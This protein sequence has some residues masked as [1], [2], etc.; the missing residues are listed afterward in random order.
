MMGISRGIS[1][2]PFFD[3]EPVPP[4]AKGVLRSRSGPSDS[5]NR[6]AEIGNRHLAVKAL[7]TGIRCVRE[8]TLDA[9][10]LFGNRMVGEVEQCHPGDKSAS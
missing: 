4:V 7:L 3:K 2:P 6:S 9:A 8:R 10:N 1:I 5:A